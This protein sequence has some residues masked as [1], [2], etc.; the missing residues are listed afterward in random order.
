MEIG[1]SYLVW[2]G[3]GHY[4]TM[5]AYLEDIEG[6]GVSK[7]LPGL[8]M[9]RAL[10]EPGAVVFVAHDNG[11][12]YSCD[13]CYG[14]IECGGC[15]VHVQKIKKWRAEADTVIERYRGERLPRGKQRIVDIREARIADA[16]ALMNECDMC[17]G[18]GVYDC[19]TGGSV[20]LRDGTTQDYRTHNYWMRHRGERFHHLYDVV[21][22]DMCET[23]GGTGKIPHGRI[24]GAFHPKR[25]EYVISGRENEIL[26]EQVSAFK[27]TRPGPGE[28]RPP[29]FYAV[30]D[31]G[32]TSIDSKRIA[33]ELKRIGAID[34]SKTLGD[35][36]VFDKPVEIRDVKRFRGMKRFGILSNG[37]GKPSFGALAK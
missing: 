19:G 28:T 11:E 9:A 25:I 37:K 35:F 3:E 21:D 1:N 17:A 29:G 10:S 18:D 2:I 16:Q 22:K 36:I 30:T 33:S 26:E 31:P 32:V 20:T 15:R 12:S 7:R 13:D 23:C 8:G 34:G 6:T 4:E 24:F 5:D 14:E 27:C